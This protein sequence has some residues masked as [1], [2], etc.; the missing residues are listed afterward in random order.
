MVGKRK[1]QNGM[2]AYRTQSQQ[3]KH[4]TKPQYAALRILA[5]AAKNLY[6]VGL[7]N[8][9]QHYFVTKEYLSYNNNYHQA[10]GNKNYK[11]LNS[12]MA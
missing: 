9:R 6:N 4:L 10:K 3:L 1:E 11:I 12:N 7:Y 5:H 8:I 2:I